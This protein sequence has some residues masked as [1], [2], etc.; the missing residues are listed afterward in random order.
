[1]ES[2][3]SNLTSQ[4]DRRGDYSLRDGRASKYVFAQAAPPLPTSLVSHPFIIYAVLK[5]KCQVNRF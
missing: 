5:D 1:M 3:T 2:R 4:V